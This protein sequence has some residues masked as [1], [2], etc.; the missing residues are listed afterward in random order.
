M[1]LGNKQ[2]D[3]LERMLATMPEEEL[4][5]FYW[6]Y[7]QAAA[8]L[9]DED[10]RTYLDPELTEDGIDD[11]AQWIVAQ[12]LNYYEKV[13]LDPSKIPP[14]LPDGAVP[15]RWT[16]LAFRS[17]RQRYGTPIRFRED[18]PPPSA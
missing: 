3:E 6:T 15:P 7:E 4:V 18:P 14:R 13:M 12:G 11:L 2:P 17:Y 8:D 9:K 5:D 1:D 16:G 10:F